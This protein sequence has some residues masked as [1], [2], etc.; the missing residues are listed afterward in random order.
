VT[1]AAIFLTIVSF[2]LCYGQ[3]ILTGEQAARQF[4]YRG[5]P[6]HPFCVGFELDQR[7]LQLSKCSATNIPPQKEG[8]SWWS[9]DYPSRQ[10]GDYFAYRALAKKGDRFL[11]ASD[12]SGGGS[13]LFTALSWVR[14]SGGSIQWIKELAFGDRC[15]GGITDYSFDRTTVRY[16][17]RHPAADL[18]QLT[19]QKLPA[20]VYDALPKA[21]TSCDG[22]ATYRYDLKTE[23]LHLDSITLPAPN[24]E[25][26][27]IPT[28]QCFDRLATARIKSGHP[29][30]TP[31]EWQ[32]FRRR[33]LSECASRIVK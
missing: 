25:P 26:A 10:R 29:K 21:A 33:F 13:G 6:I 16:G 32:E 1:R 19:G 31:K 17:Q 24:R 30:L 22:E 23:T 9:A 2:P 27:S 12:F 3:P 11:L 20:A 5:K 18:L 15:E 8:D 7:S 28:Q 4:V 14:L